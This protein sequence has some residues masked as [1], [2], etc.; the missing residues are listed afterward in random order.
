[1][2]TRYQFELEFAPMKWNALEEGERKVWAFPN[3]IPSQGAM[4][5]YQAG[6]KT[7]DAPIVT[8]SVD[9]YYMDKL[10]DK[11]KVATLR[12]AQ[13]LGERLLTLEQ[14]EMEILETLALRSVKDGEKIEADYL[15]N[16]IECIPNCVQV[17][18]VVDEADL[19]R[20]VVE[21]D[22]FEETID[23]PPQARPFLD[24]EAIG[25]M[26]MKQNAGIFHSCGYSEPQFAL[27]EVPTVYQRVVDFSS[28][29]ESAALQQSLDL[30]RS[31]QQGL[32]ELTFRHQLD[33][34]VLESVQC[35]QSDIQR[36]LDAVAAQE[37]TPMQTM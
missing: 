21:E 36:H 24:Y 19:G 2:A 28:V 27:R 17:S 14:Y 20:F 37:P 16:L 13:I 22:L 35:M 6:V 23:V 32:D 7:W 18:G 29:T 31:L 5:L 9:F 25:K 4:G 8:A 26:H 1:M 15:I 34:E 11:V 3:G 30:L 12:E 10:N 33:A